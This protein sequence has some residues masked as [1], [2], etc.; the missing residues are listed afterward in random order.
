[1]SQEDKAQR[2]TYTVVNDG[3]VEELESKLSSILEMLAP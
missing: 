1:M 2:A 3:S